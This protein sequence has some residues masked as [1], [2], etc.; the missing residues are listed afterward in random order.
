MVK[1]KGNNELGETIETKDE[2]SF[3]SGEYLTFA[4]H[5]VALQI[6]DGSIEDMTWS[7]SEME[8]FKER[9]TYL[10][11]QHAPIAY[12]YFFQESTGD[13]ILPQGTIDVILEIIRR[14][15]PTFMGGKNSG[16]ITPEDF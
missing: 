6:I 16:I 11:R 5:L 8:E 1:K 12:A 10:M 13:D 3:L 7:K 15:I 2:V 9:M 14:E 4:C